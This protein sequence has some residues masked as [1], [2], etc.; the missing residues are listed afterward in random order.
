M[1]KLKLILSMLIFSTIGIFVKN[2]PLPSSAIALFRAVIGVLFL[3]VIM[4]FRKEKISF[5][6]I[7]KNL[8]L[9]LI[10]GAF[11]G[12]NWILLFEAYR[13]TSVATATLCYYL[14]PTFIAIAAPFVL[15]EKSSVFKIVC[16][17]ISLVGMVFVSGVFPAGIAFGELKGVII[18]VC[19]AVVYACIVLLNKKMRDI[20]SFDLTFCQLLISAVVLAPYVVLTEKISFSSF[21]RKAIIILLILGVVHTGVAYALY[22]GSIKKVA[23]SSVALFS[24]IDPVGAIILSAIVLKEPISVYSVVG[25]V[26]IL[27]ASLTNE[28]KSSKS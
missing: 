9:L 24:Y 6:A 3:A 20:S 23:A 12:I 10:S 2:V 26:M 25:A 4:F 11:L 5:S 8:V 28:L 19:A 17:I 1:S 18:G 21:D 13:F 15:K 27:G 14:A 16:I 7:K 22:F